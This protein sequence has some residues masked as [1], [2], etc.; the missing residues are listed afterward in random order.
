MLEKLNNHETSANEGAPTPWD[1]LKDVPMAESA[2]G[3]GGETETK[4]LVSA[5]KTSDGG[6]HHPAAE[7][8][9]RL[10]AEIAK[11]KQSGDEAALE[12]YQ[13][14][15][16]MVVERNQLEVSP[17]EWDKMDN[18]ERERFYQLKMKEAK[19]LGDRDAFEFWNAGLKKL[20]Q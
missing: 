14:A 20:N 13:A 12:G 9:K 10:E 16:K 18:S 7:Q 15:L 4:Q 5:E 6:F 2:G 19:I 1:T 3:N 8:L 11:A 17:E